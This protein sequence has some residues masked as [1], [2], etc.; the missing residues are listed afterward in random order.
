VADCL[1]LS[2]LGTREGVTELPPLLA[3]SACLE[4]EVDLPLKLSAEFIS[5][6]LLGLDVGMATAFP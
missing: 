4:V 1:E 5:P 2:R 6:Q 3:Q